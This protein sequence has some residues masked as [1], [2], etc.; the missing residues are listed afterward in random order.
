MTSWLRRFLPPL[1]FFVML[2]GMWEFSVRI[3]RIPEWILPAPLVIVRELSDNI[4]RLQA[5]LL[6]TLRIALFGLFI[7]VLVGLFFAAFLHLFPLFKRIIYPLIL[8]SQNI[9]MIALAPLLVVWF[10]FGDLP[11]LLVVALVCFF[12]VTIA[13]LDGFRRLDPA[14]DMYMKMSGATRLQR[15]V[16]L[17][18]PSALPSFFSGLKLSATYSVMGAVIAEWL[19]SE[20][21]IGKM[22]TV[23]QKAYQTDRVFVA[24][25]L[26][27]G[28]SLLFFAF[29]AWLEKM[30]VHWHSHNEGESS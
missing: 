15:F 21:G 3:Y 2:L 17:E 22:M 11:K 1:L 6:A 10:G 8:L 24:I 18:C 20:E 29:I 19:G 26:V 30:I 5:D 23:A 28:S 16:K 13:T 7:G 25:V 27:V 9:P 4:I 12:P 14:L